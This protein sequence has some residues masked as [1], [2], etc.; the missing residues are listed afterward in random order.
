MRNFLKITKGSTKKPNKKPINKMA[1]KTQPND[2]MADTREFENFHKDI[3]FHNFDKDPI[4]YGRF[5]KKEKLEHDCYLF[6]EAITGDP[7]YIPAHF[8]IIEGIDSVMKKYRSLNGVFKIER[9]GV[10]INEK[11]GKK[12]FSYCVG[13]SKD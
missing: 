10:S 11:A 3:N 9:T 8:A 7:T 13:F 1:K 2:F 5:L 4:F 6:S 12:Y